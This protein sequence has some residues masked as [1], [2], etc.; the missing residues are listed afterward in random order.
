MAP[1]PSLTKRWPIHYPLL[2]LKHGK[3]LEPILCENSNRESCG[4]RV[5][6][7]A[8]ILCF[9][10]RN[11]LFHV[12]YRPPQRLPIES[13]LWLKL[14]IDQFHQQIFIEGLLCAKHSSE[15][16]GYSSEQNGPKPRPHGA[17]I[18]VRKTINKLHE[19]HGRFSVDDCEGGMAGYRHG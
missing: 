17:H 19:A 6:G 11:W 7:V 4:L 12:F 3:R 18:L 10:K 14:A 15:H 2:W 9:L 16:W 1:R 8:S 13:I 5:L